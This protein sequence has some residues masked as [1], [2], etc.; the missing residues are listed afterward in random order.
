MRTNKGGGAQNFIGPRGVK[1]LNTGLGTKINIAA[2][3]RPP[4][5][6]VAHLLV[7]AG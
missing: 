6:E 3:T 7:P 4:T 2:I 5:V 1:Y